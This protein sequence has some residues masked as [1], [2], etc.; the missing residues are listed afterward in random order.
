MARLTNGEKRKQMIPYV[1]SRLENS[2]LYVTKDVAKDCLQLKTNGENGIYV[3]LHTDPN[4]YEDFKKRKDD[5]I[6]TGNF[7]TGIFYKDGETFFRLLSEKSRR[8]L[9]KTTMKK[10]SYD[11]ICRIVDLRDKERETL[12][13]QKNKRLTYYQPDNNEANGRLK[14]GL[15][16][17]AFDT[18]Q[19]SYSHI[20][21]EDIRHDFVA[22]E[23]GRTLLTRVI[24]KDKVELDGRLELE[25]D[26]KC[27]H[28]PIIISTPCDSQIEKPEHKLL[29]EAEEYFLKQTGTRAEQWEEEYPIF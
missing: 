13:L 2:G 6:Y 22:P 18:T 29:R 21:T 9:A 11:K 24:S 12:R 1:I 27:Q 10:Y 4:G 19:T 17:F 8:A 25:F 3:F 20:S 7:V 26:D 15:V 16:S 23:D 28:V 14:E 5:L